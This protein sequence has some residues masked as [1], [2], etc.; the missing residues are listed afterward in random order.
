MSA[1]RCGGFVFDGKAIRLF[2]AFA[3]D[4][5]AD[6]FSLEKVIRFCISGKRKAVTVLYEPVTAFAF[7]YKFCL[8][9]DLCFFLFCSRFSCNNFF[10]C[11]LAQCEVSDRCCDEDRT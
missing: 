9:K 7:G 3:L 5:I 11:T 2:L 8:G 4:V 10:A 6:L 1:K